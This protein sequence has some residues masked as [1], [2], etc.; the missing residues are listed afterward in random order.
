MSSLANYLLPDGRLAFNS[1]DCN[2]IDI[3]DV[4]VGSGGGSGGGSV[5][6]ALAFVNNTSQT[7]PDAAN[8]N[9]ILGTAD[10]ENTFGTTT[11]TQMFDG[12]SNTIGV[13][14]NGSNSICLL[15]TGYC[16]FTGNNS[17]VGPYAIWINKN[18]NDND[19]YGLCE[20][21]VDN[22]FIVLNF[23]CSVQLAPND[24]INLR[25]WVNIS[26][27]VTA[28]NA[29]FQP[30]LRFI[31]TQMNEGSGGGG[32]GGSETLQQVLTNGNNGGNLNMTNLNNITC[33]N[34]NVSTINNSAYP[35]SSG[36]SVGTL[37]QVLAQGASAGNSGATNF[38]SIGFNNSGIT[39][40]I[41]AGGTSGILQV[42][43]SSGTVGNVYDDTINPP[44]S[45]GGGSSVAQKCITRKFSS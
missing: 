1:I 42:K 13:Q 30:A 28:S 36:G 24:Y 23:S 12:S 43:N 7:L 41:Q 21:N 11:L 40:T 33:S 15:V 31:A 25:C 34:L 39:T 9:L 45:G 5:A 37:A 35:P 29:P 8:I 3:D 14:N 22:D 19:R 10:S 38:S 27:T 20:S 26:V 2:E 6:G 4:P 17:A 16:T 44:P 32:S 18:G